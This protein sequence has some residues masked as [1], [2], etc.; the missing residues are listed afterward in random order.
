ML[1]VVACGLQAAWC[2]NGGQRGRGQG[3]DGVAARELA[4]AVGP[5]ADG[6]PP[7]LVHLVVPGDELRPGREDV[8]KRRSALAIEQFAALARSVGG[9]QPRGPALFGTARQRGVLHALAGHHACMLGPIARDARH[10]C[11]LK[12]RDFSVHQP[13]K[14][15]RAAAAANVLLLSRRHGHAVVR[16]SAGLGALRRLVDGPPCATGH[17][18]GWIG[19]GQGR[20]APCVLKRD[21]PPRRARPFR[22]SAGSAVRPVVT[23]AHIMSTTPRPAASGVADGPGISLAS[24]HGAAVSPLRAQLPN[25]S[26]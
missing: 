5:K 13:R 4:Q 11:K 9:A 24:V 3:R 18:A 15:P 20:S 26:A 22:Q 8:S 25:C 2:R 7:E 12:S 1:A 6:A 14:L 17:A 19:R 21:S 16:A 23:S 10:A